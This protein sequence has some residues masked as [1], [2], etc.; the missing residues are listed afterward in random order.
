M[1][2]VSARLSASSKSAHRD[3]CARHASAALTRLPASVA[4]QIA[5]A[6]V[7]TP[8]GLE[9]RGA[10]DAIAIQ[11]GR[12]CNTAP[13]A[14][15]RTALR[16]SAFHYRTRS[17]GNASGG[18]LRRC[19]APSR[20]PSGTEHECWSAATRAG[21][22]PP[23]SRVAPAMVTCC[24]ARHFHATHECQHNGQDGRHVVQIKHATSYVPGGAV[25]QCA[26]VQRAARCRCSLSRATDL[27]LHCAR[28]VDQRAHA[29]RPL[30]VEG[31]CG[32]RGAARLRDR[33]LGAY[34]ASLHIP[35]LDHAWVPPVAGLVR[36]YV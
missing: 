15:S 22:P 9:T 8:V 33:Q 7:S 20:T 14:M 1:H 30:A 12:P 19:W 10:P 2:V 17:I 35:A 32:R 34:E 13:G 31:G 3:A 29:A 25:C 16:S 6:P 36:V 28:R 11:N 26:A 21:E 18:A 23:G 24:R 4:D 27:A 5:A